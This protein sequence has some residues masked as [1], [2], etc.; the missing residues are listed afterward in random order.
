MGVAEKGSN[1][2]RK[3]KSVAQ[4]G[5]TSLPAGNLINA[6]VDQVNQFENGIKQTVD[7]VQ[8]KVKGL[9]ANLL[10][11][12]QANK[13]LEV[14]NRDLHKKL[15]GLEKD[16]AHLNMMLDRNQMEL[17]VLKAKL[18]N[19]GKLV[20]GYEESIAAVSRSVKAKRK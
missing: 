13:E 6:V 19:I 16:N 2:L 11:M 3:L 17:D 18:E 8:D 4:K 7:G 1:A 5:A 12:Y 15:V 14:E 20:S 9:Q 10:K